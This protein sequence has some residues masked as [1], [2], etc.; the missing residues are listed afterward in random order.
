M[1]T[2]PKHLEQW[3]GPKGFTTTVH[4]MDVRPGGVWRLTMRGPDGVDYKNRI[5]YVDVAKPERLVYKHEPEKGSEPV[6]F[7][8]TVTFVAR[9]E[10]T[11]V[12]VRQLF[13]TAA[14]REHVEEKHHAIE[15]LNQTLGRLAEHLA[16]RNAKGGASGQPGDYPEFVL[17]RVFDAPR[18]LVFQALTHAEHLKHWWGPRGFV[19]VSGTLDLRPGGLFHYCMRAPN[20]PEM[21]GKFVYREIVAPE[22]IVFVNA[23][24]DKDGNSTRNPWMP[25]WPVEVLN[26]VTLSE[27]YGKTIV[28]LRGRPVNATEEERATFAAGVE[29]MR[30]GFGGTFDQLAEYLTKL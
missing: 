15:G 8:T 14:V 7:E 19:C 12:T 11:E 3:W 30:K 2:E 22:R 10:K 17:T 25:T 20:G 6:S 24:S 21:W 28:T 1:W 4:E 5:V 16:Q 26:T 9:D 13:P 27:R 18:A 29:S 23:F